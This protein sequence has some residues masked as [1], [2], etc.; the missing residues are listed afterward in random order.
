MKP[1]PSLVDGS[2]IVVAMKATTETQFSKVQGE[3]L[4][5]TGG[6]TRTATGRASRAATTSGNGRR[7]VNFNLRRC[8]EDTLLNAAVLVGSWKKQ[9]PAPRPASSGSGSAKVE[10]HGRDV[11]AQ[12]MSSLGRSSVNQPFG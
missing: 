6:A 10:R 8:H 7:R 9:F 11:A 2:K 3:L 1:V 4:L 12:A 5:A